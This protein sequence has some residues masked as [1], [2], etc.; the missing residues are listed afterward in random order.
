MAT[1]SPEGRRSI[2]I[3]VNL[4][5]D[6]GTNRVHVTSNDPDLGPGGLSTN[7][8]PGSQA[9]RAAKAALTMHGKPAGS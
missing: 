6:E 3:E 4:W 5:W 9:E 2:K 7:F 8:K 1:P